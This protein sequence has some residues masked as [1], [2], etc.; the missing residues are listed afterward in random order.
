MMKM[1][2]LPTSA[3]GHSSTDELFE[4]LELQQAS[5]AFK[6]GEV[7]KKLLSAEACPSTFE[8]GDERLLT[9]LALELFKANFADDHELWG[10]SAEKAE[11]FLERGG[12]LSDKIT[13]KVSAHKKK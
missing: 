2:P 12:P 9:A 8:R 1:A 10:L 7:M 6:W 3:P 5:G 13:A 11:R 4:L